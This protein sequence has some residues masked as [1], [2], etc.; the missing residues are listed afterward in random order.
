MADNNS[1]D[2]KEF[3]AETLVQII[4]AVDDARNRIANG[5]AMARTWLFWRERTRV[6]KNTIISVLYRDKPC[7]SDMAAMRR[8]T[9]H[10]RLEP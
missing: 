2:L 4:E 1:M 7:G 5:E 8:N 9:N 3:V 10:S 6:G